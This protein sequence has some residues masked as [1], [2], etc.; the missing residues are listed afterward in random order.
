MELIH[1]DLRCSR[2][3]DAAALREWYGSPRASRANDESYL[4]LFRVLSLEMWMRA[5]SVS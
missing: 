1:D 4:G 5:F 3:I 2:Y